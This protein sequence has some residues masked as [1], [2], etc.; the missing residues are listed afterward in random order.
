MDPV[1]FTDCKWE[2][3]CER[4]MACVFHLHNQFD[5]LLQKNTIQNTSLCVYLNHTTAEH[6]TGLLIFSTVFEI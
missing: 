3:G 6:D 1:P 5:D 2:V 4:C